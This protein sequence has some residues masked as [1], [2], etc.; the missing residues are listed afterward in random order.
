MAAAHG[1]VIADTWPIVRLGI[2]RA[3]PGLSYRVVAEAATAAE[4]VAAV[5]RLAPDL[6]IV[7]TNLDNPTAL[8]AGAKDS[9]AR[10]LALVD[11][12]GREELVALATAGADGILTGSASAADVLD[13]VGRVMAGDRVLAPSLLPALVGLVQPDAGD[14]TDRLLTDR[15]RQVLACLVR[16]VRNEEI[17]RQLYLS[18]A[19]VKTHLNHI[20]AKLEVSNRH[21]AMARAIELGLVG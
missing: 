1:V 2:G 14:A 21:E 3:L 16:G 4:G 12:V 9:G 20:Y 10:A 6:V 5:R 18:P 11:R 7:G 15:E 8:V 13:A 17:A 19:T